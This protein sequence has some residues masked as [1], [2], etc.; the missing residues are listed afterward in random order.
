MRSRP[1]GSEV[2]VTFAPGRYVLPNG[3]TVLHQANP[4]SP[5]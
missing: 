3:L 4:L 5:R 2:A 1:A